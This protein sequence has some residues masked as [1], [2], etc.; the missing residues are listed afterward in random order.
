MDNLTHINHKIV[1]ALNGRNSLLKIFHNGYRFDCKLDIIKSPD[2]KQTS[3][4]VDLDNFSVQRDKRPNRFARHINH[5]YEPLDHYFDLQCWIVLRND[6]MRTINNKFND[7]LI[8]SEKNSEQLDLLNKMGFKGAHWFANG[9]L[10]AKHWF[11]NYKD[12]RIVTERTPIVNK[13]ICPARLIDNQRKYRIQFLN[14]LNLEQGIYS[15]L[16]RD[17]QTQKTP[18]EI[19]PRNKVSPSSFDSHENSSAWINVIEFVHSRWVPTIWKSSFLHVVLETVVDRQHLTEKIF[20]PI[21]LRQPFVLVGGIGSLEYLRSY[22]FKT[23]GSFWD[24]SY[25]EI[26]NLDERMQAIADIVNNIGAMSLNELES[27]RTGMQEIL[28][29]NYNRFYNGFSK[30]CWQELSEQLSN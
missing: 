12:I 14:M 6:N 8:H 7:T 29:H 10:C 5:S 21:V 19:Y 20:K 26:E 22:G 25:D 30:D 17:P 13:F 27:M 9:Y 28:D 18:E 1:D 4:L 15:L 23:F 24:E 3:N 11:S 2:G 16:E